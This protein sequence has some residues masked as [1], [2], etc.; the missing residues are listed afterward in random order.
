MV[1]PERRSGGYPSFM[2][3]EKASGVASKSDWA[4]CGEETGRTALL[5]WEEGH[6]CITGVLFCCSYD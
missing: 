6:D 1:V 4:R 2:Y 5:G 3:E